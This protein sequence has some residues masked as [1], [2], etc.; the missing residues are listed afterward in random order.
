MEDE[1]ENNW[2]YKSLRPYSYGF[3]AGCAICAVSAAVVFYGL[4]RV[5][6]YSFVVEKEIV[7]II[8]SLIFAAMMI[9]VAVYAVLLVKNEKLKAEKRRCLREDLSAAELLKLSEE[10]RQSPFMFSTFYILNDHLYIPQARIIL[11][12]SEIERIDI[13]IRRWKRVVKIG[14]RAKITD[15]DGAQYIVNIAMWQKF[16]EQQELF[17]A[18]LNKRNQ[19]TLTKQYNRKDRFTWIFQ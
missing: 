9:A 3:S 17:M 8:F 4:I 13:T 6:Y 1:K 12:Y 19:K 11:G 14:A 16:L 18:D 2:L 10:I 7:Y 15:S 5:I